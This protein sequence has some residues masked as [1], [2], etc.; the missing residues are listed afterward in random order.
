MST[1]Y[2]WH[3]P[4]S[5]EPKDPPIVLHQ[6]CWSGGFGGKKLVQTAVRVRGLSKALRYFSRLL[7]STS[8]LHNIL[9]HGCAVLFRLAF[10]RNKKKNLHVWVS[11]LYFK[12]RWVEA[13]FWGC[14][15]ECRRQSYIL[16]SSLSQET[17]LIH[18][19]DP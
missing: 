14:N 9:V 19:N 15:I 13:L 17:Q 11:Q 1:T 10:V 5:L 18:G 12:Q 2:F 8:F 4:F 6:F 16:Y 7:L 3:H